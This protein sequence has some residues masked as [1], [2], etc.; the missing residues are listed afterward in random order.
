M[1]ALRIPNDRRARLLAD[2]LLA[3]NS[4][5]EEILHGLTH[6][7]SQFLIDAGEAAP[8]DAAALERRCELALRHEQARLRIAF[9]DD[10]GSADEEFR[11]RAETR[12]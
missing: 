3:I 7:E 2:G 4:R 5:S 11:L 10:E 8:G 9:A 6:E 12:F 1:Q